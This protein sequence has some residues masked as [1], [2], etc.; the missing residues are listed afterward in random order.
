MQIF[1]LVNGTQIVIF[2]RKRK[3][4]Q[5]LIPESINTYI[6]NTIIFTLQDFIPSTLLPVSSI[7][8]SSIFSIFAIFSVC[9]IYSVFPVSAISAISS[10]LAI[11]SI[12][13]IA[14]I[15]TAWLA[16]LKVKFS[17]ILI[18]MKNSVKCE[19]NQ[20]QYEHLNSLTYVN[21]IKTYI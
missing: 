16:A 14:S 17:N 9:S 13:A 11:L 12:L 1:L 3:K 2:A 6:E 10:I 4:Q 18:K 8:I 15:S 5:S 7:R 19:V 20:L 21:V